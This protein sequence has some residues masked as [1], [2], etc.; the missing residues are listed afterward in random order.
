MKTSWFLLDVGESNP[1][2]AFDALPT[3]CVLVE[4]GMII[5]VNS[6]LADLIGLPKT[7]IIGQ[8]LESLVSDTNQEHLSQILA[9]SNGGPQRIT[10]TLKVAKCKQIEMSVQI[11]TQQKSGTEKQRSLIT[12]SEKAHTESHST[13]PTPSISSV[14]ESSDAVSYTHLTLPTIYSV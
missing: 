11:N 10:L 5:E 13:G 3:G 8:S 4:D 2:L 14:I 12:L 9:Q 1:F 7:K 6:Y